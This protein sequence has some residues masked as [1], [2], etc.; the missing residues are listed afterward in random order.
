MEVIQDGQESVELEIQFVA[1]KLHLP[2]L[3]CSTNLCH[4]RGFHFYVRGEHLEVVDYDRIGVVPLKKVRLLHL[5]SP[6]NYR[7]YRRKRCS[8]P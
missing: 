8:D 6:H 3:C 7:G 1:F 4:G 2:V 5:V